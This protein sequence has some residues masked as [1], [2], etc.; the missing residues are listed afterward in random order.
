M[1][2]KR[3]LKFF[4]KL[5]FKKKVIVVFILIA[6]VVVSM[7]LRNNSDRSGYI[8]TRAERASLTEVVS[9]SGSIASDGNTP[10]YS[11]TNGTI[12]E[13]YVDNGESVKQGQNLFKVT[14]SATEVE[15]QTAYATYLAAKAVLDADNAGLYSL[16][17][18]MYSKW[19]TYTDIATNSTFENADK[20]PKT[21]NRVL[22][23]FTTAQDDWLAAE[24][25]YK[26]QQSVIAKDQA[27]VNSAY[28][29]YMA[30]QTTVVK[31]PLE[32]IVSNLSYS[33]GNSVSAH[34]ALALSANPVLI[35]KNSDSLE[36]V[37]PVGQTNIAK[38]E[39][40]QQVTIEP[41][42]Y[43]DK[44]YSGTVVRVD[45]IG[46]NNQGVVNYNV[47]ANVEGDIY[48]KPGM[49]FD[50]NIVTKKLENVLTVPNSAVVL[51]KGVKSVRVVDKSGLRY[52]PVI[53]G[54]KGETR[55]QVL[56]GISE[57]QEI[58]SGLTNV[59]AER[60]GFLGI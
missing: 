46:E 6:A 37:I 56:S 48:L 8:F 3:Y 33:T 7:S 4:S 18:T 41:D 5:S 58:V 14:S 53:V 42:A 25:N 19:K 2:V 54:I 47:Y 29:S 43:K 24:A 20:T 15:K 1:S 23:T 35:M 60:P 17:S 39:T 11:P 52:I 13:I 30:T 27:S 26:N 9:E 32:G 44:E 16:Q 38:V 36:A 21:E 10:V 57:G 51:N 31:S 50:S 34:T 49:T 55:T 45:S 40:G 59:K 28:T 22:T 12:S